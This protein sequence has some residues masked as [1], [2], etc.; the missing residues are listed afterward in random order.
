MMAGF[1]IG[2]DYTKECES[3]AN[4]TSVPARCIKYFAK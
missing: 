3:Y 1:F 2:E 4:K